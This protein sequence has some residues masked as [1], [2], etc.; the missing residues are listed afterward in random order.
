MNTPQ[1]RA[2]RIAMWTARGRDLLW[3][4][5]M[6][7]VSHLVVFALIGTG[8][9]SIYIPLTIF[10]VFMSIMGIMGSLDAMDDIATAALDADE[11]EK[12]T[13]AWKRFSETQWGAFKGLLA[14]WFGGT[15]L[16]EL[17][18]MWII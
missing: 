17:Y 2:N 18:V 4:M 11:D 13:K 15:A 16:A 5:S 1:D 10:V 7:V 12:K 8:Y 9:S 14:L 3:I 6:V